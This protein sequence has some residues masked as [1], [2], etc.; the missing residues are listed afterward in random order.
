M[1]TEPITLSYQ[2][3]RA[4][5]ETG[6]KA[7][8]TYLTKLMRAHPAKE[9]ILLGVILGGFLVVLQFGFGVDLD[10]GDILTFAI[11]ALMAITLIIWLVKR[12]TD[13]LLKRVLEEEAK[14]GTTHARFGPEGVNFT[15]DLGE[16]HL[17]WPAISE[18]VLFDTGT[19][20]VTSVIAYPIP[21]AAMP[22]GLT[23]DA[24]RRLLENWR[25]A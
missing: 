25:A 1:S 22:E 10:T 3:D 18:I 16:L 19:L 5:A 12:Q 4:F 14:R 23:P 7:W 17:N 20:L 13:Q 11:G 8:N 9:A 2:A 21:D 6:M 15:S 24:F